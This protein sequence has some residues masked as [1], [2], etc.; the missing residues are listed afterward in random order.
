MSNYVVYHLH[1][2]LSNGV[3]NIDSVTKY[4]QYIERAQSL[5]MSAMAFSEHGSVF[6]WLKKK[7]GIEK[8]GMKYIHA[9]EFYVTESLNEK[10][11]DNYHC[12]LI[13]KNYDGFLELNRLS[14]KAFNRAEVKIYDDKER[15]YY[16]PRITYQE[17]VNTSDNIII[18]TA[19]LANILNKGDGGLQTSFVKFLS[20]NKHRCFLEIQHHNVKAQAEYNKK[21]YDISLQTGIPLIAGTDTHCLDERHSKGRTILQKS[22]NIFFADENGWDLTFKTYDEL[23]QCYMAQGIL[24]PDVFL[25]AIQNTNV[26][27]DMIEPFE[28]DRSYKYP[29]LWEN[30][31]QTFKEKVRAGAKARGVD[32]FPNKKEYYDRANY[33]TKAYV[34]NQAI[35]FMLLT[36]DIV[37]YCKKHD[38]GIG[39][40]RGSVNGSIIAWMLGIT[41]MDSIK[42]NLNFERFMNTERVSLSDIDTDFPPSRRDEVKQY[43]CNKQGLYCSDIVTFNTIA[44][45]GAIRDVGRAMEIPLNAVDEI[46]KLTDTNEQEA[47]NQYPELFEY[48][49]IV[50]GTIVSVGSHP[51]GL[52]TAPH[53]IDDRLG[54]FTTLTSAYP[55]SQINMKEVDSLNYVKLDLLSLDTIELINETCKL[56]GIERLTPD[57]VDITDVNVW[58]SIRDDTTQIFQWE[59]MMGNDYIKKLLSDDNIKKFKEINENV[60]RMTLLSIGNSAIRPAGA[61]YRDDLANGVVRKTGSKVIDDF[62]SNTFGYLV[63]QCQIIEFLHKYCGFTMGE[64]DI[65]RRGFAKKTGTEQF[66]PVI[67]DGGYLNGNTNHYIKG[68]IST[69]AD[70]YNIPKEKSE[71]D[72]VDFIQVI[73]DASSYLFSLNH[74][75]PYSYE[76]YVSGYLRYYYPVEFLTTAL[77]INQD[78]QEKTKEVTDYARKVGIKIKSAKFRHSS[79]IYMPDKKDHAIYKGVASIKFLNSD[80]A[81]QLYNMRDM[82][83]N[84]FI[85]FLKINPCNSRQTQILIMLG[86]FS[87][88]GKSNKLLQIYDIYNK[89]NGKKQMTKDKVQL[90]E[91]TVLKYA[92]ATAKQYKFTDIDGLIQELCNQVE[93][94]NIS[95]TDMLNAQNEYLGYIDYINPQAKGYAFVTDINTKY[96]PKI[97]LYMLET[98]ETVTVKVSKKMLSEYPFENNTI[99]KRIT[100]ESRPKSHLIDGKW[101]KSDNEFDLW[102]TSY[103]VR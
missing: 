4:N 74:S 99:L 1:S 86:Y 79:D 45:K 56:A 90:P 50:N 34:H 96:T 82:D 16:V 24:S 75:Q 17:L 38:I 39:Y 40:G 11:R 69:M 48:V 31:M 28:M 41:E 2:D 58:N 12:V 6:Q 10:M 32:K 53:T 42:H 14:S 83:F 68:F 67:K 43:I 52:I 46:C 97:T 78:K 26:M 61:S 59:G 76:G 9:S 21:L 72:I 100:T 49:D 5:G 70:E 84:S 81:K 51:C 87:E 22:K 103:T 44:L 54:L 15:F 36:E 85:D 57:N 33:E 3:T 55:I 30:S 64:A 23:C 98:G 102:M 88:F 37:D 80:V 73:N 62:L 60:D 77:N 27:A 63:F 25:T 8:A 93:D 18:T 35:D 13:A 29:H 7:E 89:Y 92:T 101:V 47:R 94:K 19:C 95:I 20:K 91:E 71:K 66:I 65:V